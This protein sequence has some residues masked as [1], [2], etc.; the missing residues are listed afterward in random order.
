MKF[1]AF[2][3]SQ[4]F[5]EGLDLLGIILE[6]K[7]NNPRVF[8]DRECYQ[9]EPQLVRFYLFVPIMECLCCYITSDVSNDLIK[10]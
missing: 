8:V 2:G 5:I 1:L 3:A 6:M 10:L 7:Y 9:V 4:F